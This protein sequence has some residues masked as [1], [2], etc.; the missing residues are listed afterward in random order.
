MFASDQPA[1]VSRGQADL[2]LGSG[3]V[4]A[5]VTDIPFARE[6]LLVALPVSHPLA[7]ESHIRLKDLQ[8]TPFA[9]QSKP[10]SIRAIADQLFAEA[11]FEP[12]VSFKS[13]DVPSRSGG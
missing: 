13:Q 9:L 2:A 10:H 7:N 6:E 3:A 12:V 1:A 5:Q 11:G 8:D 4:S